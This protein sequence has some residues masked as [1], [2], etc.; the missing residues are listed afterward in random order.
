MIVA[1]ATPKHKGL[2]IDKDGIFTT[3]SIKPPNRIML[4]IK[5]Q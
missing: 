1:I 3:P 2:I 4:E 5:R